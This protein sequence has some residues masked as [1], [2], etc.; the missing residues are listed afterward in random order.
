MKLPQNSQANVVKSWKIRFFL[1][2]TQANAGSLSNPQKHRTDNNA[3]KTGVWDDDMMGRGWDGAVDERFAVGSE[4]ETESESLTETERY[5]YYVKYLPTLNSSITTQLEQWI[6]VYKY[7][8]PQ[9]CTLQHPLYPSHSQRHHPGVEFIMWHGVYLNLPHSFR[10]Q[11]NVLII[12]NML[13]WYVWWPAFY[14]YLCTQIF[15]L[16]LGIWKV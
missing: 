2:C 1:C 13:I 11:F 10:R 4:K 16:W 8:F 3:S 14:R 6:Y 9:Y 12:F 7:N 15:R 5:F